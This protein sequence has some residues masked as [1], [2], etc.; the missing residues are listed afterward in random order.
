L[1]LAS[2]IK[3]YG[4]DHFKVA[5]HRNTLGLA[6]RELGLNNK[7]ISYFEQALKALQKSNGEGQQHSRTVANNLES[8]LLEEQLTLDSH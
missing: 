4:E 6:W 1:A 2:D 3:T 7:A 8:V 5:L